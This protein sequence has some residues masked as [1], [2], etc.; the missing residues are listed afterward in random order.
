M[1]APA[2]EL[3]PDLEHQRIKTNGVELHVVTAGPSD[4]PLVILLH[5]FPEFWYGWRHQ[6]GPLAAAGFRVVAPDQRGYNLSDKPRGLASYTR[7]VLARD[8]VGL[9]DHFGADRAHLVAHD[10]G[11]AVAWW[12]ALQHPERVA[13]L[14]ALNIPHPVAM[15]RALRGLT[16]L[17]R[18]WYIAFF[19]LP[20]LPEALLAR[21]GYAPLLSVL[22][23]SCRPGAMSSEER[24]CYREAFGRPGALRAMLAWYRAVV[25][26]QT[27]RLRSRLVEAPTLLIWGLRDDALGWQMAQPSIDLCREGRLEMIEDAGHFVAL[28]APGRVNALLLDFLRA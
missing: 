10:W 24:A 20:W 4:G 26:R 3:P 9:I 11:G 5:G 6:I 18:S 16:Q 19:Q 17:R 1:T 15:A 25:Q 21:K 22:T 2:P 13:R 8:V 27:E 12:T 28:D 7:D 23:R 14:A